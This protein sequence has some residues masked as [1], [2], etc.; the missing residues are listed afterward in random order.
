MPAP[1]VERCSPSPPPPPPVIL[2]CPAEARE[3]HQ[4]AQCGYVRVPLDRAKP[5]GRTIRVYFE[6]YP[7]RNRST[8]ADLDRR[9]ARGRP[10]AT[11]RP[12]AAPA[13]STSGDRSRGATTSSSSTCAEP[14]GARPIGCRAFTRPYDATS[15]RAGRCAAAGRARSATSSP[16]RRRCR[17]WRRCSARC[18]RGRSTS[19]ATRTAPTP[20]RP[21][22][23]ASRAAALAALDGAYPLPGTDPAWADL[24]EAVRIGLELACGP[25]GDLPGAPT[26]SSS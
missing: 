25:P 5:G 8:P 10:R 6:R 11:R 3:L 21:T 18:T 24:V 7:R 9:L 2:P 15:P 22:R 14:A 16:P 13:A 4:A 17:T 20:R 19:T 1:I 12:R 26:R 23:C